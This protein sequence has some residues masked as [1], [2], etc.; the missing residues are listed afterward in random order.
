MRFRDSKYQ[1]VLLP[2]LFRY[3]YYIE[4]QHKN[5]HFYYF[6]QLYFYKRL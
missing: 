1:R 6:F 2:V 4:I 3:F 5:V